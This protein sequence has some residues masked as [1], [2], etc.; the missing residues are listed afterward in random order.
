M[1]ATD[2]SATWDTSLSAL[3]RSKMKLSALDQSPIAQGETARQAIEHT[4]A[5][6]RRCDELGYHRYWLAEHHA[7]KTLACCSPEILIG[8]VA[9][10][11][12]RIRVG[13]GGVMLSHY[14]PFK[15][16]E[17]FKLLE[18]M[19]PGRIDLGVGRAPGSDQL[20]M[21]A[22]A[23]GNRLGIEYYPSKVK[24]ML[25]WV[26]GKKPFT[27]GFETLEVTPQTGTVPEVWILASSMGS[28][29]YAAQFG[30]PLSFAHFIEPKPAIEV[31]QAYRR[32]FKPGHL[33]RPY[34]SV[35]VFAI[36]HEDPERVDLFR[37]MR[38]LQRI[39]RD[40]GIRGPTP[41]LEEAAN[42][43]F[44]QEQLERMSNKRSR[45]IIGTP[46]QVKAEIDE[47]VDATDA[48][49]V[50]ILTITPSQEDRVRS[51]ELIAREY[52]L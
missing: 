36:A 23:Y 5:L 22:L 12:S 50:V 10:E 2:V 52:S 4:I 14:S 15:V 33:E 1:Y 43:N 28:A 49:E 26:T 27:G 17:N 25:A 46:T 24:D 51:Y 11:T 44:S 29:M 3:G 19:Y 35:G 6:A 38:E 48:D 21:Q 18:L 45:Q 41:T 8:R 31:M 20:T 16:A 9:Q 47:L 37:R 30:L 40:R 13:S 34:S 32:E 39:R 42:Y 7:S